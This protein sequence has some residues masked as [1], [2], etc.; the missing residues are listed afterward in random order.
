MKLKE[1]HLQTQLTPVQHRFELHQLTYFNS[2]YCS[3]R[4]SAD[5]WMYRTINTEKKKVEVLV[6]Q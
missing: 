2:K 6:T 4:W 5:G 1:I 3:N